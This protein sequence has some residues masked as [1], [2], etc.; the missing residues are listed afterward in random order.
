[1]VLKGYSIYSSVTVF[2]YLVK[3]NFLKMIIT[4][5]IFGV[6]SSDFTQFRDKQKQIFSNIL[7]IHISNLSPSHLRYSWFWVFSVPQMLIVTCCK[8]GSVVHNIKNEP[9]EVFSKEEQAPE[10]LT[11]IS[12]ARYFFVLSSLVDENIIYPFNTKS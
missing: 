7:K 1:M 5:F 2:Y 12:S 11:T 10:P 8:I 3:Y 9:L 4:F 6:V